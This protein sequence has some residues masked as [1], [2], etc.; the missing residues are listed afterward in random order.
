MKYKDE[1][2]LSRYSE[3]VNP[4]TIFFIF[5]LFIGL[6]SSLVEVCNRDSSYLLKFIQEGVAL[7]IFL[8]MCTFSVI[9]LLM[10]DRLVSRETR[11][12]SFIK[13][14]LESALDLGVGIGA[15]SISVII[16]YSLGGIIVFLIF[17]DEKFDVAV[18]L[19]MLGI[20]YIVLWYFVV[21][22]GGIVRQR[23]TTLENVLAI[24]GLLLVLLSYIYISPQLNASFRLALLFVTLGF[25]IIT[26]ANV[27]FKTLHK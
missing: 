12:I 6:L 3:L 13:T 26:L 8:Y 22:F 25:G 9:V 1:S 17:G 23:I 18:K 14:G 15:A 2:A 10:I 16:S 27:I 21:Y 4:V 24:V 11:F 7:N 20:G 5:G 19:L